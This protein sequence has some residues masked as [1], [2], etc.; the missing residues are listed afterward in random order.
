MD[1]QT[2]KERVGYE[3][4]IGTNETV[5]A[6]IKDRKTTGIPDLDR[7]LSAADFAN[8]RAVQWMEENGDP[9]L[10]LQLTGN[11]SIGGITAYNTE[12]GTMQYCVTGQW[13]IDNR[14]SSQHSA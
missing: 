12:H 13:L 9:K 11:G 4:L 5:K 14:S 8:Q 7:K 3:Y 10:L 2:E 1:L 6:M